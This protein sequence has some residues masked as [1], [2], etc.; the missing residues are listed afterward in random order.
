MLQRPSTSD[1]PKAQASD[2]IWVNHSN[3]TIS[4]SSSSS[5][6]ANRNKRVSRDDF[7]INTKASAG[8]KSYTPPDWDPAPPRPRHG[9]EP[10]QAAAAVPSSPANP[11]ANSKSKLQ[12]MPSRKKGTWNPQAAQHSKHSPV[13]SSNVA[14]PSPPPGV[15]STAY[16]DPPPKKQAGKWNLLGRL[17]RKLSVSA[18]ADSAESRAARRKE[19]GEPEGSWQVPSRSNTTASR[20]TA[21]SKPLMSRSATAP[22]VNPLAEHGVPVPPMRHQAANGTFCT[23]GSIPIALDTGASAGNPASDLMLNVEIPQVEM[24]RYS[25]MFSSVLQKQP[26]TTIAQRRQGNPDH[27][28]V[29]SGMGY[30]PEVRR[31]NGFSNLATLK[32]TNN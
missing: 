8:L 26:N 27:L 11:P 18:N 17:G 15:S 23:S 5:N 19:R 30:N 7:Y 14:P 22:F 25:I 3:T 9:S 29:N 21:K 12:R 10:S 4:S 6:N 24:E 2:D 16:F 13:P 1:G 31:H 28:R 20:K 32:L